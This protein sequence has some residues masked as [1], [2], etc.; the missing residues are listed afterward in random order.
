MSAID[1]IVEILHRAS[2]LL[3]ITGAGLSADSGLPTYRGIGGLY[4]SGE[5]E[6][7]MPIE[8]ALS[9]QTF[10]RRPD[11][12]WKYIHQIETACRG[13]THNRGHEVIAEMESHFERVWVLT[14]NV[15]GFH[16]SAGSTNVIDIHGDVHALLCT[17][18]GVRWR[19]ENYEGVDPVPLCVDCNGLVR[20]DVVLFGEMLPMVKVHLMTRELSYGFD[21]IFSVGT[22]SLFPYIAAPVFEAAQRG[23]ATVE[24]NP[25][26]TAVTPFVDVKLEMGAAEAFE[27]IWTAFKAGRH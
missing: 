23:I 12:C 22:T 4:N 21:A 26:D 25:G 1:P 15:D 20:P 3:F 8:V 13:A 2:S 18:C 19:V 27:A 14:Q 11:I 10:E 6:E 5:T 16:R 24:I 7:G 9:G 17:Q